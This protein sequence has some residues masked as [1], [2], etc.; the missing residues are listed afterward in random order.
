M[1]RAAQGVVIECDMAVT[2]ILIMIDQTIQKFILEELDETHLFVNPTH[3]DWIL[4]N[5]ERILEENTYRATAN[6]KDD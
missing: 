2:Q 5:L 4:K 1:V 3:L 6:E